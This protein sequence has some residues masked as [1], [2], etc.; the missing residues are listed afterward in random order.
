MDCKQKRMRLVGCFG[1]IENIKRQSLFNP[2]QVAVSSSDLKR[3]NRTTPSWWTV[4]GQLWCMV[5]G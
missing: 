1:Q 3:E 2:A 5:K 4:G